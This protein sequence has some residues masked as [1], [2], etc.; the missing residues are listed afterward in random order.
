[1]VKRTAKRIGDRL[2]FRGR[3]RHPVGASFRRRRLMGLA[4]A[5]VAPLAA[6]AV[7]PLQLG[8]P[9]DGGQAPAATP[10][11]PPLT[12][13]QAL[14]VGAPLLRQRHPRGLVMGVSGS[15]RVFDSRVVGTYEYLDYVR[16]W[17]LD[18]YAPEETCRIQYPVR[19]GVLH[20][21]GSSSTISPGGLAHVMALADEHFPD[22]LL[23][24][25]A[26]VALA[27]AAGAAEFKRAERAQLRTMGLSGKSDGSLVWDVFISRIAD[28]PRMGIS[29]TL[30]LDARTGA[31]NSLRDG[32]VERT[33][34]AA[35]VPQSADAAR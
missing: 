9:D 27:D 34:T 24:S 7:Q 18:V 16:D 35:A 31:I 30:E 17:V 20:E 19:A 1:M 26:A 25:D 32:R 22:D 29:I 23:D 12:A 6:C 11:T 33:A 28:G 3:A 8:D 2:W 4:L 15:T 14:A 10:E 13:L 21:A 5:V